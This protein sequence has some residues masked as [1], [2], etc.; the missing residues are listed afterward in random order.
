M[1]PVLLTDSHI[2]EANAGVVNFN[3]QD[4]FGTRAIHVGSEPNPETGAVIPSIS[5]ATTY[6]QDA[7]G[8]HKVSFSLG[9]P[10]IPEARL[11]TLAIDSDLIHCRGLS[12][13]G[14]ITP[15]ATPSNKH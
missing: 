6:K 1:S 11:R 7:I 4:G 8:V 13:P 3:Y 2:P 9:R 15:I 12:I 5:L 10:L 14:L